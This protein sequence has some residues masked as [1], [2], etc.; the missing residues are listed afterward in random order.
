ML[1]EPRVFPDD[2]GFFLEAYRYSDFVAHGI[3]AF[4][5]ENHSHS[6]KGIL[7]GMHFQIPPF[8]QGK[9]VRVVAGEVVDVG[10]DLRRA[11]PTFGKSVAIR[12]SADNKLMLYLP[13]WCA[14]GFEVLSEEAE[15]IYKVTAE[16]NKD[17]ERG[18][19]WSDPD[20]GI[21]WPD[22]QPT[23]NKRDEGFPPLAEL[24]EY[25]V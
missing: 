6:R 20:L 3:P 11:S 8:S 18:L 7:R 25:F 5:Q 13:P 10:V 19:L 21:D 14:H 9:L 17:A 1:I 16:Y 15:V 2:R 4:V 12:L 24:P 23:L 22:K